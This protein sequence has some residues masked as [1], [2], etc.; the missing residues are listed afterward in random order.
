MAILQRKLVTLHRNYETTGDE[1]IKNG[2]LHFINTT[3]KPVGSL[4][5]SKGSGEH[6][7]RFS[8][9]FDDGITILL[10][11]IKDEIVYENMISVGMD[12]YFLKNMKWPSGKNLEKRTKLAVDYVQKNIKNNRYKQLKK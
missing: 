7:P 4:V 9:Q 10:H 3:M 11:T 8:V 6:Q 2:W 5:N 12:T 1:D